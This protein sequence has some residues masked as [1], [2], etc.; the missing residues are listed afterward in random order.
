VDRLKQT[1]LEKEEYFFVRDF[2]TAYTAFSNTNDSLLE[3][4]NIPSKIKQ[5]VQR[6]G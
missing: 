1:M 6:I 3:I 5:I 2:K 4:E